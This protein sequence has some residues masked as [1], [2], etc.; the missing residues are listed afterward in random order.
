MD[1]SYA[2]V[3]VSPSRDSRVVWSEGIHVHQP[4]SP[5][6]AIE[7]PKDSVCTDPDEIRCVS[8]YRPFS[9]VDAKNCAVIVVRVRSATGKS[10]EGALIEVGWNPHRIPAVHE[11]AD[12]CR[13]V[14]SFVEIVLQGGRH[15]EISSV[16][17]ISDV[18]VM[19]VPACHDRR[20]SRTTQRRCGMSVAESDSLTPD[21]A[22]GRPHDSGCARPLVVGQGDEHVWPTPSPERFIVQFRGGEGGSL[23]WAGFGDLRVNSRV[24]YL[25]LG[26]RSE[27]CNGEAA[28]P[29]PAAWA[30]GTRRMRSIRA[31]AQSPPF[32]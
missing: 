11:F 8:F 10:K 4:G 31:P 29:H 15:P 19:R 5:I 17:V 27:N 23:H 12:D 6:S 20:P 21:E 7:L 14:T 24:W 32:Q 26:R 1:S 13:Q 30:C 22:P 3:S 2:R 18:M 25:T 9:S 16:E 28:R